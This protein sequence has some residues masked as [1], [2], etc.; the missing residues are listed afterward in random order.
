MKRVD[1]YKF[2]S[3]ASRQIVKAWIAREPAAAEIPRTPLGKPLA[4]AVV[5]LVTTA[6]AALR[7]DRP[8]DQEGE[9]RNPWWGDPTCRVLPRDA[10]ERDVA[11]YHLHIDT[12]FGERDLNCVLPL[13]RLLELEGA[14]AIRRSAPS[15]YSF[16]GYLLDTRELVEVHLPAV[17][18]QMKTEE[19]DV[20][21]LVPV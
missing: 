9:R 17:I 12:S 20:A 13:Q 7:T 8:F 16:M 18:R 21:L 4:E 19:V 1:S 3:L 6:G 14:G 11:L 10:T 5:A 15:H 2:L